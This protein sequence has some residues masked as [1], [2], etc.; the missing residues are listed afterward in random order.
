MVGRY[1]AGRTLRA[2]LTVIAVVT[3]V[4]VLVRALPG[5]PA[6]L[7][8]GE[9]ATP[10]D[11]A[12]M[13]TRLHLDASL[14]D[15]YVLFLGDVV[16]GS[17][18]RSFRAPDRTVSSRVAEVLP[19]TAAL[20]FAA[21]VFAWCVA[22]PLGVVAAMR[23]DRPIDLVARGVALSG[24]A[25]PTIWLGPLLV[26]LFAVELRVL[27]MPGDD[28]GGLLAL[29]LPAVTIGAALAAALT[30]QT[31]GAMIEALSEPY[32]AAARARG[33]SKARAAVVHGL[34]NALVP[35]VTVGASQLGAL[36]GGAVIA[37][38]IFERQGLGTLMLEAFAARDVPVLQGA[39]LVIAFAY[40]GIQFALDLVLAALDP[41]VRLS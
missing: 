24:V 30:R 37:E 40:V 7:I 13:R 14:L 25:L 8:L 27:P 31:R 4:F 20:A 2:L 26:L 19:D 5:D 39:V 9:S 21:T 17:L 16:D 12:A 33:L 22:I 15:Q 41:R 38:K 28:E 3:L 35:V 34:R 6:V 10:R 18:G 29:V 23:R 36:L 32:V 11:L 1:L